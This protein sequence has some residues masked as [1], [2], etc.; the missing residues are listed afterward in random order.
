[1]SSHFG[2]FRRAAWSRVFGSRLAAGVLGSVIAA[3]CMPASVAAADG[4]VPP[5]DAAA[6]PAAPG[7]PKRPAKSGSDRDHRV[8][9]NFK[10]AT[11]SRVLKRVAKHAELTLI[12]KR[13]PPGTFTRN[14]LNEYTVAE[15]LWILNRDLEP[16]GYRVVRQG[17]FLMVLDLDALRSDYKPSVARREPPRDDDAPKSQSASGVQ[18]ASG[19]QS[20]GS[21]AQ[22]ALLESVAP[23]TAHEAADAPSVK[24]DKDDDIATRK[25]RLT[26]F[27]TPWSMVLPKVAKQSGLILVMKRCPAGAFQHPDFRQYTVLEAIEIINHELEDT[28]F[29]LIRQDNFLIVLYTEDLRSEYDRPVIH[30]RRHQEPRSDDTSESRSPAARTNFDIRQVSAESAASSPDSGVKVPTT[31]DAER[32]TPDAESGPMLLDANASPTPPAPIAAPAV[33]PQK[34]DAPE[35]PATTATQTTIFV[36][37]HGTAADVAKHLYA[38]LRTRS[39]LLANGLQGLPSFRVFDAPKD[40]HQGSGRAPAAVAIDKEQAAALPTTFIV[41]LDTDHNRLVLEARPKRLNAVIRLCERLDA[42]GEGTGEPLELVTADAQTCAVAKNLG[43]EL[44][45]LVA[46]RG[47]VE[48]VAQVTPGTPSTGQSISPSNGNQPATGAQAAP[49][50][51]EKGISEIIKGLKGDVAVESVPDLGILILRGGQSDVDAV[52]KVIREIERLSVGSTPQIHLLQL[53]YV[54]SESF[55]KLL[56]EVYKALSASRTEGAGAGKQLI[57]VFP[58]VK[59][60]AVLVLAPPADMASVLKLASELDQPVN[61][62]LEFQVFRLRYGYATQVAQSVTEFYK[63]P[64]ALGTAVNVFADARTNSLIIQA[65]P[66]DLVEVGRLVEKLDG[67]TASQATI[68]VFA[69]QNADATSIQRLLET[70]FGS[71]QQRAGNT[72]PGQPTEEGASQTAAPTTLRVSVDVRTNTIIALG[73]PDTLRAV[74]AVIT[75]LDNSDVHQRQTMVIRLKNNAADNVARAITDFVRSQRDLQQIEP[76]AMS[77]VEVLEREV[78][79]VSEPISNSLLLSATPRY[80]DDLKK[81]IDKLDAPPAQVIIQALIVEVTLN[82]DDEFGIELGFQSPVLFNRSNIGNLT[83]TTTTFQ[84]VST[85]VQNTNVLSSTASPGFQFGDPSAGLGTNPSQT[86]AQV[87]TQELTNF[88]VGRISPTEG[89][90]GLVL[91]ASSESVSALLRAL[92]YKQTIHILSRPQIRTL[93]NRLA[94]IQVGKRVPIVYSATTNALGNIQPIIQYDNAGIILT[95]QPRIT[96]DGMIA[97]EAYAEKSQ[98]EPGGVTLLSTVGGGSIQSPIKDITRAEASVNVASGNTVVMGG[99]ITSSDTLTTAKVPWLGDVPIIG[100][101]FRYDS[102]LTVRTE[103]LI[104]LTPRVIRDDADDEMIKQVETERVHFLVD[105]AE[106]MHGPIMSSR[107]P[108]LG[109]CPADGTLPPLLAVPGMPN[110]GMPSSGLPGSV[111]PGPSMQAPSLPMPPAVGPAPGPVAPPV[112]QPVPQSAPVLPPPAMPPVGSRT[113]FNLAPTSTAGTTTSAPSSAQSSTQSGG[114]LPQP[115]PLSGPP[116]SKP[117]TGTPTDGKPVSQSQ[118]AEDTG[119]VRAAAFEA[120][121]W[122]TN[123]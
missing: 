21:G 63:S 106:A 83:T 2:S 75:R 1:M 3:G 101:V 103:L 37:Q 17:D 40:R 28:N 54:N 48:T 42:H 45:R 9:L 49:G 29:R 13:V 44:N 12:M 115:A 35:E 46:Q 80:F 92:S 107:P 38:A 76:E 105:E 72:N 24:D 119:S 112:P 96:P 67:P 58:V 52:M 88:G 108:V 20:A 16:A 53:Q 95:V 74:E 89:I 78:F 34:P 69:L 117:L 120:S 118:P 32:R 82:N 6:A 7:K 5:V 22:P 64:R 86:T 66:R 11:W 41:G 113:Y 71:G 87:G 60:N 26:Y 18:P 110:S 79:V 81:M 31:L 43:P 14:D 19:Q 99:M 102:R 57:Q 33:A 30:A 56:N 104:F 116:V 62:E 70:L 85:T 10:A 50:T 47:P 36:P 90:G 4:D 100:Q 68:K 73:S 55:S 65:R 84:N 77:N 51:G 39:E 61:P 122:E 109:E 94:S 111:M 91:A 97:L 93:D 8:R 123:K 98:Y 121:A 15:V 25:I 23:E 27:S 114:T 59:P